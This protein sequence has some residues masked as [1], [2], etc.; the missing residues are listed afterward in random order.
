MREIVNKLTAKYINEKI[1]YA[2]ELLTSTK[3]RSNIVT[4]KPNNIL[5]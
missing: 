2:E 5:K 3:L 4:N 1:L